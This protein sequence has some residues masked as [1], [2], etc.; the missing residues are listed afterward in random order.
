MLHPISSSELY[1]LI[2]K[3]NVPEAIVQPGENMSSPFACWVKRELQGPLE[4]ITL[5][6]SFGNSRWE[7]FIAVN[8][9]R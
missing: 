2:V 8:S 9:N 6:H 5:H 4:E 1:F 3:K 7:R